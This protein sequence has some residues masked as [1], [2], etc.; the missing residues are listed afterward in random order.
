M[1]TAPSRF[2]SPAAGGDGRG[3]CRAPGWEVARPLLHCGKARHPCQVPAAPA[4][5]SE[6]AMPFSVLFW[7][8]GGI[9]AG[10]RGSAPPTP[11]KITAKYVLFLSPCQ[12]W[13]YFGSDERVARRCQGSRGDTCALAGVPPAASS[14]SQ[15]WLE[16][17]DVQSS[18]PRWMQSSPGTGMMHGSLLP[19]CTRYLR[20]I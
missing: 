6:Q 8:G 11:L 20:I 14:R 12:R 3:G 17:P 13:D 16:H 18:A 4:A 15:T 10:L 1:P 2:P 5:G 7:P 19:K 9:G